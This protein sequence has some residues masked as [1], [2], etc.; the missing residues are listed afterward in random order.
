MAARARTRKLLDF[1]QAVKSYRGFLEGTEKS[2]QTIAGYMGDLTAFGEYLSRTQRGAPPAPRALTLKHLETYADHLKAENFKA[3]TR[4]RKLLT[5]RRFFRYLNVRKQTTE[6]IGHHLP[7]PYKL[8]KIPRILAPTELLT[9]IRELPA[10]TK[11]DR[12]NRL[13]L[14]MLVETGVLVSEVAQLR[15]EDFE[16]GKLN[17][18]GKNPRTLTLSPELKQELE[19]LRG[20]ARPGQAYVFLGFNRV[21]PVSTR[22]SDRGVELLV[23]AYQA[24][25]GMRGLT[26]RLIRHSV[27]VGWLSAGV[28]ADEVKR[29]LGLRS[30]YAFRAYAPLIATKSKNETTSNA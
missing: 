25:L 2:A 4:R 5:V 15:F 7:T 20:E 12:R 9:G 27:A 30:D 26:P 18:R 28:A 8:E 22:I 1:A 14:W 29:R 10:E 16:G 11:L 19:R 6:N 13:M 3:N 24:K 17:V 23:R 21:G